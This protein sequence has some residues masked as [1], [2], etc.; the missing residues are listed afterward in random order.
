MAS[1]T[2]QTGYFCSS[3]VFRKIKYTV[4]MKNK[5][6][7]SKIKRRSG[8]ARWFQKKPDWFHFWGVL[9][10]QKLSSQYGVEHGLIPVEI[11]SK[12]TIGFSSLRFW[13]LSVAQEIWQL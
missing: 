11:E 13:F 7:F 3:P 8:A 2:N 10:L 1:E 12:F 6:S 5:T 9:C 4:H